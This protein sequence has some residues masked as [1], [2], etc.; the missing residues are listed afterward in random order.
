MRP[1]AARSPADTFSRV[2]GRC[3]RRSPT[4]WDPGDPPLYTKE[5]TEK[6]YIYSDV[7]CTHT[8]TPDKNGS[9][10]GSVV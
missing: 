1:G 5:A 6:F 8:H 2:P 10:K 3:L 7:T 9:S 4:P